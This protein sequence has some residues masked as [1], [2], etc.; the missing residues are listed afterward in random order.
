Q[1]GRAF[2]TG[3]QPDSAARPHFVVVAD[4]NGDTRPDLVVA[5]HDGNS[6]SVLLGE[7]DGTF[8]DT[9]E[10]LRRHTFDVGQ[11]PLYLAVADLNGDRVPDIVTADF[12]SGDNPGRT[13]TL[14]PGQG[15]GQFGPAQ[16]FDAGSRP[17][18][19]EVG[20]VNGD[21]HLDL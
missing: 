4:V 16:T 12:G 7:G 17:A 18:A 8:R 15:N 1:P 2:Q 6:V 10:D 21:G 5:N 20:D 14:L 19:V 11:G 13:L 9:P 3:A